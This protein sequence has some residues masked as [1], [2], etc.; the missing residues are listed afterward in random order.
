MTAHG[1]HRP[2]MGSSR[3]GGMDTRRERGYEFGDVPHA[4]RMMP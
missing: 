3:L 2:A 4:F 1:R